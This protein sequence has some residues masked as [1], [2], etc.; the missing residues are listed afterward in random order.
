MELKVLMIGN[1]YCYYYVEELCGMA[2]AT[3]V[4]LKLYNVYA[5]G[6]SLE[7]HWT[8]YQQ[9]EGDILLYQTDSEG[10]RRIK[11]V[12]N[13]ED[14]LAKEEWDVISLQT[15]TKPIGTTFEEYVASEKDSEGYYLQHMYEMLK[16]KF[17]NARYLWHRS[18]ERDVY[19]EGS[20]PYSPQTRK[21]QIQAYNLTERYTTE[22][23]RK[24]FPQFDIV[25]TGNAWELARRDGITGLCGSTWNGNPAKKPDYINGDYVHDG[26]IGGGNYLN[27]CV[28]FEILFGKSCIGN[29]YLADYTLNSYAGI[30]DTKEA[31][32]QYAHRAVAGEV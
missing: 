10:R 6:C 25:P 14:C 29:S 18:W 30:A 21:Q 12:R 17:P 9:D 8:W 22:V 2:K 24:E 3:G 20:Y 31:L 28:W 32:Q 1:S 23:I 4:D 7:Q 19:P 11:D 27:A 26:N 13:L 5:D 16:E 15:N